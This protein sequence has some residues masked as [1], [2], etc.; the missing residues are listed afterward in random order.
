MVRPYLGKGQNMWSEVSQD[1]F[2]LTILD[3]VEHFGYWIVCEYTNAFLKIQ[4]FGYV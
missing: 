1:D 3:H 4:L 2:G